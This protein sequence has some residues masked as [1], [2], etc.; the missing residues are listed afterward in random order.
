MIPHVIHYCWFGGK[1]LPKS[2][3]KCISSWKKY[4]PDWEIKQWNEENF[5][6]NS[7]PYT[8][9]AAE[10][11]KWAFVSDYARFWILYHHGGVYFDTDVEVIRPMDDII[12]GGAFMGFE[13][14]CNSIG[15]AAGLG[16]GAN[17][18]LGNFYSNFDYQ[19]DTR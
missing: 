4:F 9:E 17:K 12:E 16:M 7:I 15:I 11:G 8:R 19:P 13:K 1:P 18:K 3:L 14:D 10:R 2:A 5:D 6:I